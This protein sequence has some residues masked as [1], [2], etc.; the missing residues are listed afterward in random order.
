VNI[1]EWFVLALIV[2]A[3]VNASGC[4]QQQPPDPPRAPVATSG[5]TV[6]LTPRALALTGVRTERAQVSAVPESF[7]TTGEIEFDPSRVVMVNAPVSG[8]VRRLSVAVGDRVNEGDTLA[9]I[10]NPEF[11]SGSAASIAPRGGLVTSVNSASQQF[12]TAG[13][14]LLKI[15]A[16]DRVWLRVDL[17]GERAQ[18]A[19]VG[20]P[21]EARV[22][23]FPDQ[24]WHGTIAAMAPSVE[25]AT[26]AVAARVPLDNPDGRL[27]PG[28]FADVQV[29]TGGSTRG[30][31]VPRDAV[32]EQGGRRLVMVQADSSFFPSVVV[33][34]PAVG[35]RVTVTRGINPG[36]RIVVKGAYEV[37]NAGYSF[38]RG[39]EGDETP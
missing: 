30:V 37:F 17:Y 29:N 28:M 20:V 26:Q 8:R 27:L 2:S 25:G 16:V 12:L 10:E 7:A 33:L 34:G 24:R 5:S 36:E 23:A 18:L 21:V 1:R 31:L 32:I 39:A 38:T 4:R 19:R 15:A 22:G 3:A 35:E 11:L 14:E 6:V 13:A 9:T